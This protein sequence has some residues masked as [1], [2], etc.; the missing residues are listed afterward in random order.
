MGRMDDLLRKAGHGLSRPSPED[1]AKPPRFTRPTPP[2]DAPGQSYDQARQFRSTPPPV[3]DD[4][5]P[6]DPDLDGPLEGEEGLRI[7]DAPPQR[8]P[9]SDEDKQRLV[10]LFAPASPQAKRIDMLRSQLLYPFHGDPPR[11]IMITSAAPREG[12][13]LLTTNLAIS[14]ARGLQEFVLVI[15]CH[16][17]APAIHRLLQVPLRPGLTDYLE[18]GAA[19]PEVI[20]WTAV[21]KLSVIPAGRPSQRTAEILATDKMVDMMFELRERYS[22]RYIILDTPPVQEVDDPAVLARVVEGIVFVALGGVTERDQVLRAMRSLPEEK[23]V[24]MVLNDPQAAVLDAP[25]LAGLSET[26]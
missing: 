23:I 21:D 16:L 9:L 1:E 2:A 25:A 20:H 17:A 11:T 24:G 18:H 12:R 13:S 22:D 6:Y 10:S 26:L 3:D 4:L 8:E 15:D 7:V 5:P 14:F 19:L